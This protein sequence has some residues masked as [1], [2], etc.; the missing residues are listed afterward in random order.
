MREGAAGRASAGE[1]QCA[2][3]VLDLVPGTHARSCGAP[4]RH[5]R[6]SAGA[7]TGAR[8]ELAP[9]CFDSDFDERFGPIDTQ[10]QTVRAR[11]DHRDRVAGQRGTA[12]RGRHHRPAGLD[13]IFEVCVERTQQQVDAVHDRRARGNEPRRDRIEMNRIE[14]A[15]QPRERL[16]VGWRE[17]QRR[18]VHHRESKL[19]RS[20]S[21]SPL[22]SAASP[23][24]FSENQS[25]TLRRSN[26]SK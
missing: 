2:M 8:P 18:D 1:A 4:R 12:K 16:L 6:H 11:S 24:P 26:G 22:N 14:V 23:G 25:R 21:L 17:S 15:G 10:H 9:V 19:G 5:L 20:W 7:F 13:A 3:R